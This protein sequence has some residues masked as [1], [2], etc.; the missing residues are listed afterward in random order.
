MSKIEAAIE[1][2]KNWLKSKDGLCRLHIDE[3]DNANGILFAVYAYYLLHDLDLL[4]DSD[5]VRFEYSNIKLQIK[6]G[7]YSRTLSNWEREAHDNYVG[8][9]AGAVLFELPHIIEEI[10]A[11]GEA[12]DW[13]YN[14]MKPDVYQVECVRQPGERAFYKMCI[15]RKPK[16]WELG[17]FL[18]GM[19]LN[20]CSLLTWLRIRALGVK[21]KRGDRCGMGLT[22]LL[23]Y[24]IV[25]LIWGIR[26][27]LH[28]SLK[29]M[30]HNY[31]TDADHPIREL[32]L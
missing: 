9:C 17:H 19:A 4:E 2:R 18:I 8:W 5:A 10:V 7:L 31:F 13:C 32:A 22:G 27:S 24:S 20:K 11:Y 28:A 15:D 30:F 21:I 26:T 25:V 12:K 1:L 16:W 14:N 6:A 3:E 23:L 29:D